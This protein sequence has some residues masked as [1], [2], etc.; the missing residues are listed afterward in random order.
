MDTVNRPGFR[1]T[2][3][4]IAALAHIFGLTACILTLVWLLHYRGGLAYDSRSA[5]LVFNCH[6]F[7]ML[8]GFVIVSGE[9]IMAY[10]TVRADKMTTK[11]VHMALHF[12][13]ICMGIVGI[14]AAFKF[15]D[16]IKLEH[17]FS[18]HSWIGI[19]TFCLYGLQWLLGLCTFLFTGKGSGTTKQVEVEV[20]LQNNSQ[21]DV[22][23]DTQETSEN[24]DEEPEAEQVTPE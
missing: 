10:K 13:A 14:N 4:A 20:E 11:I 3:S 19:V 6:P 24:V 18:L 16:M 1:H 22:V 9:A 2:A 12:V 17:M 15:H 7:F 21:G 8:L 5:D 23:A